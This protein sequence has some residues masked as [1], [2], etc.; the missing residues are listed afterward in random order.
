MN[1]FKFIVVSVLSLSSLAAQDK[2]LINTYNRSVTSLNG[3][4]NYIVDP[5]ENGFYNYRYQPFENQQI[6]GNGAYFTNAKPKSPSDLIEYDFDA[7]DSLHVP[8][9]WNTQKEKLYYYEGTIWYKKSFDYIKIKDSNRVFVYFEAANYQADVY[10][11]GK[12]LGKH[13]G[14]FTP[15]NFE[16]TQL[17]K[18]TDNFLVVKVDNKRIKEGVPTLNTDWWNYGGLTRDVKLI[19]TASNFIQDYF[20]Q[21]DPKNKEHI[22]GHIALNGKDI[23]SKKIQLEIPDLKI[24]KTFTT[25]NQGIAFINLKHNNI[26]YWSPSNPYLYK[27]ILKTDD[28]ELIDSIGFRSVK[29]QGKNILINEQPIFLKGI[30]IHEESPIRGG[31]AYNKDDAQQLLEW[32]KEL[33]C[34]YVRLAHYPHNEH[35]IRLADK[36]GI[37]VWEENPVYWTIA[38]ENKDT[39]QNAENQL[40]EVINRDKNRASVIIWSM[41]NETPT[42]EARNIF[43]GKLASKT[44]ALDPTRLISAALEQSS[45]QGS[46]TVRTIADDFAEQVD[47]LSFNQY[48][49]WYDGLPE[50]ARTI[51]W[52]ITQNKPVLISEF[53][54]GA[55][56][57]YHG[58]KE[59]R[60]TEEYQ[61][62]LYVETLKMISNIDQLQGFSPWILVDFRSPRRPLPKIQD[63][64]NRKGLISEKGEKKKAFFVLK[65]F[66]NKN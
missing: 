25:D 42:S 36:M 43:L 58:A 14:G 56:F 33:G 47:V 61:E 22:V 59:T 32:A 63:D 6:P 45:Y 28:D 41:A 7:S 66:Y 20:I 44:R 8:G 23:A 11:N 17:L 15:F 50:K 51:K 40:T 19:E 48:I 54:A 13:T 3:Y 27:V 4:W 35:M 29:T 37:L 60:W 30:S 24:K 57:G 52:K 62:Y 26:N 5:Y 39:Y 31:R 12:K 16:I 2:L 34:N 53:G 21:L 18:E 55:K 49:G 64:W 65:E 38:W 10:L 46:T 1:I 9:D